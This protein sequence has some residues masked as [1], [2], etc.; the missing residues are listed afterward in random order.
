MTIDRVRTGATAATALVLL[1]ASAACGGTTRGD[2]EDQAAPQA[3]G[4]AD[5][6]AEIPAGLSVA[7]LPKQLNNPYFTVADAGGEAAVTEYAG[8]YREVGPSEATASSQV[9]YINTL[10]QQQTDVIVTAANDP[11]AIC[12]ALNQARQAGATVVTFD[13][14][15]DPACRDLFVNQASAEG[16]AQTQIELISEQIGGE[17][18]IAILSATPNATNQNAWIE[19]MEAELER[20]EY[21]GIELVTVAYGNDDDQDSFQETQGLLQSYPDLAGIVSPT[22]V[23]IAAAAR[24]LSGSEYRGEVALTGL[25]TPNQMREYV[26]DGTVEAFALWNPEDLGYLAAWAGAALSAGQITGAEGETFTAGRLGEYEVGANGEVVLG[27]PTVFDADNID[28]F[29]F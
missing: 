5:P 14:D 26:E 6:N 4:Q 11:N 15:T 27:P 3:T 24:Y 8:E 10:S 18:Q 29:D 1:L 28:D 17:G 2:A 13:S 21:E 12:G 22:T 19:L 25:G 7:F 20:P 16:I 23:G 9:S